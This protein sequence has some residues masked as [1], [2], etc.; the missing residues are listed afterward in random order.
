M[1]IGFISNGFAV[2][3][4]TSMVVILGIKGRDGGVPIGRTF[5]DMKRNYLYQAS[6]LRLVYLGPIPTY[7]TIIIIKHAF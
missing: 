4:T 1:I 2:S 6:P 5:L 7:D 3:A